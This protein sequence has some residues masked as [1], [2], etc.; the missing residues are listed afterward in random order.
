MEVDLFLELARPPA[1]LGGAQPSEASVYD[2]LIS[3]SKTADSFGVGAL[4]LPEHHFLGDYSISSAP[5]L[6]L[7]AVA[8][9]TSSI[10]LGLAIV[11]LPVHD[12]VRV[13]ERLATL[14]VLSGGRV[15]WGV[16]RGATKTELDG[17]GI[18][19]EETR[20]MFCDRL[21]TLRYLLRTG[22]YHRNGQ[23]FVLNPKPSS[24]LLEGW[25]AAVSPESFELAAH[26]KLGVLTGPFKPW[27]MIKADLKRYRAAH[28]K[29]RI[30]YT[31]AAYC[32]EDHE[33]ARKRAEP[34]I[35][36]AYQR[37]IDVTRTMMVKQVAGYE[38]YRKLGWITPMLQGLLNLN[39]LE[40]LGLACVG[41]PEHLL[42]RLATLNEFGVDRVSL[43]MGGGD[44]SAT[45]ISRSLDL[46][47][48]E[49][50]PKIKVSPLTLSVGEAAE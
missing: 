45:E 16:G 33:V 44:L 32:D 29:G 20:E 17:F 37:L 36:W 30:S 11:P 25:M 39:I 31:I 38:H 14:D 13:A 9:E 50:M 49:V 7:A 22:V 42:R 47:M 10:R 27:P 40:T 41:S 12:T 24:R 21:S 35:K 1:S 4:W 34:G 5:D 26:L 8:R 23:E 46:I 43:V 19:P 6:L 18:K 15:M 28:P 48:C 2:D 3:V